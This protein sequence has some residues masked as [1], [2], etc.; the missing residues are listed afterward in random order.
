MTTFEKILILLYGLFTV[1][2]LV[3]VTY[4]YAAQKPTQS[5]CPCHCNFEDYP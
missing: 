3:C 1:T 2:S 5:K 4:L